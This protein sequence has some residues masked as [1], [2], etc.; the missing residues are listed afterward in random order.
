M[1]IVSDTR[2]PSVIL[3]VFIFLIITAA[4]NIVIVVIEI[5]RRKFP[6]ITR[7]ALMTLLLPEKVINLRY[8]EE[9][10]VWP[11]TCPALRDCCGEM[12]QEPPA[13]KGHHHHRECHLLRRLQYLRNLAQDDEVWRT[14]A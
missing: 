9:G 10:R 3:I 7:I 8:N 5:V 12:T 2:L 4:V 11:Q 6:T 13:L 14:G 1:I